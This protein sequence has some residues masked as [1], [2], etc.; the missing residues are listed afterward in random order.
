MI[1]LHIL[2]LLEDNGFGEID[3]DLFFEKLTLD[4]KGLYITSRGAPLNRSTRKTQ[5]F[6]IY[7]RGA[8]DTDG[9]KMLE[10]VVS[11]LEEAYGTVCDLPPVPPI[12]IKEYKN[13]SIQPTSNIE[14]VGLD[15][16][17]RIIYVVSGQIQY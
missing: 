2:K 17:N 3:T 6:D 11:F 8:N 16:N 9:Y 14:N 5:A 12:S 7:A 4:K 13:C 1:A 15:A 10:D